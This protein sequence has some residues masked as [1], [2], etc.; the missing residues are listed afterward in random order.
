MRTSSRPRWP[1]SALKAERRSTTASPKACEHLELGH[2]EKRALIVVSDGGDNA[3]RQ[4]YA[5]VL[6]LARR[7]DAVIY[8][9]GLLGTSPGEDEE[10]AGLLKRLCK[11]T[12]GVAYFP[13]T[14]DE[15]AAASAASRAR[16]PRPVH[17][18]LRP[19]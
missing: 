4:T 8:A 1:R 11:D 16:S 13:R 6:A 10:D 2:A 12:G 15:I 3:S 9:I 18:R 17:A 7:S 14:T 5:E 19:R